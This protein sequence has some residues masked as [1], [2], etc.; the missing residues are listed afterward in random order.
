MMIK[1]EEYHGDLRLKSQPQSRVYLTKETD[2]YINQEDIVVRDNKKNSLKS[3]ICL[4]KPEDIWIKNLEILKNNQTFECPYSP[5]WTVKDMYTNEIITNKGIVLPKEDMYQ[6]LVNDRYS[7][8]CNNKH[9]MRFF[10]TYLAN[11]GQIQNNIPYCQNIDNKELFDVFKTLKVD[12]KFNDW[13]LLDEFTNEKIGDLAEN[14]DTIECTINGRYT[15]RTKDKDEELLKRLY[16]IGANAN[17]TQYFNLVIEKHEYNTGNSI[18]DNL[19]SSLVDYGF[20][21]MI[22]LLLIFNLYYGFLNY[23]W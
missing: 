16:C 18:Q 14:P 13:Q 22:L 4:T 5:Y 21:L 19:N 3:L 12:S 10:V 6:Q 9:S 7:V 17:S 2:A 1:Y 11:M 8:F 15:I 23:L 20:V